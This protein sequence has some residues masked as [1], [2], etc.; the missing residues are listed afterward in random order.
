MKVQIQVKRLIIFWHI[1]KIQI[2]KFKWIYKCK[3]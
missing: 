3:N 1:K 2:F